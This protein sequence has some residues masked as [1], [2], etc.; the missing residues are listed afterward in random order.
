MTHRITPSTVLL[1]L[2]PPFLWAGNAVLGRIVSDM[3]PPITLNFLRW[4]IAFLILLPLGH[5]VLRRGSDLWARR[6]R[7]ALLGLLGVGLYNTLQYMALH[8]ST[9]INVTLV[10]ASMP[11]WMLVVGLLFFGA[12]IGG[13]QLVGAALSM[14][15]VLVVL[16]HGQWEQ[17]LSMRFVAGDVFMIVATIVWAFYSWLLTRGGE[18]GGIRRNWATLLLAQISFGVV[19]SGG[20]AAGEWALTDARIDWSW[21]LAAAL[22]YFA[23]GPAIVA[24]R[25]W[26]A[27]V[28]RVGP[29]IA[30]FF[31][32]LTPLF[33]ALMSSA[34]LGETPHAYHAVAFLFIVGG[35]VL[36]SRSRPAS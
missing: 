16:S 3:V 10:G 34:F 27:G 19:W 26:G 24:F 30:G 12:R 13:H 25:C 2:V 15:G 36:S 7:Y 28:G 29:T 4:A 17:L 21:G 22:I 23:V 11:V 14:M 9:P 35:I 20:F 8:T 33:A 1:L 6:K 18:E 32:N 31:N 5:S